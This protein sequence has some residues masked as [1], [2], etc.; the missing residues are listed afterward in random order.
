MG[1]IVYIM[2]RQ[3]LL[4]FVK[5]YDYCGAGFCARDH[6][7]QLNLFFCDKFKGKRC[8]GKSVLLG[9]DIFPVHL[10]SSQCLQCQKYSLFLTL[11][12]SY[13]IG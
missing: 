9:E 11:G 1:V 4:T 13:T 10:I 2:L 6:Q 12:P 3:K 8:S 5:F 7:S